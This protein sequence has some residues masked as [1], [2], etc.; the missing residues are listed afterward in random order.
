MLFYLCRKEKH[1]H[2]HTHTE[3][4]VGEREK[5]NADERIEKEGD[6]FWVK[7]GRKTRAD[8]R[9]ESKGEL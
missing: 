7:G 2:T 6:T 3:R 1:T 4:R 5:R 8:K 9:V